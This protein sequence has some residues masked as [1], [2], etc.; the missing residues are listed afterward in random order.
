M[1]I[2]GT[3]IAYIV[4]AVLSSSVV[5]VLITKYFERNADTANAFK[6]TAEGTDVLTQ[7]WE[8]SVVS[9]T[10]QMEY[11]REQ[12]EQLQLEL[13]EARKAIAKLRAELRRYERDHDDGFESGG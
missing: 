10:S 6:S 12:I 13:R 3:T 2:T 4:A 11:Q 8:R 9:L 5:T 7:A 1:T